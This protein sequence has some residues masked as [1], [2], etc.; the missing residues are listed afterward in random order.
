MPV[1]ADKDLFRGGMAWQARH[2]QDLAAQ[3]HHET[4][5]GGEP[6]FTDL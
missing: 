1:L 5:P 3:R 4:G 2:G 6:G